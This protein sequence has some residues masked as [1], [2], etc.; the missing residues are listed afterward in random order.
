MCSDTSEDLCLDNKYEHSQI[1]SLMRAKRE[2]SESNYALGFLRKGFR[3]EGKSVLIE[4]LSG[5]WGLTL[6]CASDGLKP[7]YLDTLSK[8]NYSTRAEK[9]CF[10]SSLSR[11]WSS[12]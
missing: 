5:E 8:S 2:S 3:R 11:L 4:M 12:P 7:L 6:G 1:Y 9:C 10:V